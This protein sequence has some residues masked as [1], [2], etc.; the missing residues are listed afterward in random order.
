MAGLVRRV[1]RA[2]LVVTVSVAGLLF[3]LGATDAAA[4]SC[5]SAGDS[6]LVIVMTNEVVTLSKGSLSAINVNG[7][8]CAGKTASNTET[9][10][11]VASG[12]V[13]GTP[14][15]TDDG[16]LVVDMAGGR[17]EPGV[18]GPSEGVSINE[19]EIVVL[20]GDG[21]GAYLTRLEVR[22]NA[23]PDLVYAGDG[24]G[25]SD[26]DNG[27]AD[28]ALALTLGDADIDEVGIV[29]LNG[30]GDAD[31]YL[32]EATTLG[33]A[34]DDYS[35]VLRGRTGNDTLGGSG[36]SGTGPDTSEELL[37]DGG[38]GDDLLLGG[39]GDDIFVGG[40]GNDTIDGNDNASEPCDIDADVFISIATGEV[41]HTFVGPDGV[42]GDTVDYSAATGPI[43]ADLD[44]AEKHP[45]VAT[46]EGTDTLQNVENIA[47]SPANDTLSGDGAENLLI[48]NGGDDT[49]AGDSG[50]DC[51]FGADG[52]DT[53]DENEG[54]TVAQ[55]G[56]GTD[57]GADLLF[58]NR[59]LDDT[60]TYASRTT[61]VNVYLE[62]LD[63]IGVQPGE[64]S[65]CRIGGVRAPLSVPPRPAIEDGADLDGDGESAD[66]EGDCVFLDTENAITGSGNDVIA[67][68]FLNNRADNELTPNG[69]ND[70]VDGGAGNDTMH[71][72][73]A[74]NG[75][76]D[77]DGGTGADTCD[78]SGRANAVTVSLEGADN[79][80]ERGEGD[81]CGG[82]VNNGLE[83]QE[84]GDPI[85]GPDVE[86][87][88]GGSGGDTLVGDDDANVLTANGGNDTLSGGPGA[89]VL[90]GG[91]GDDTLAGERGNDALTG[92]AGSDTADYASA[93]AGGVGVH[94]NLARGT[95]SG[96]GNDSLADIENV[97]G[98]SFSDSLRGSSG[99]NVLSGHGGDDAI[100]GDA[101]D[102]RLNG[103]AGDDQL[104]G[105]S[106]NDEADGGGGADVVR[107]EGGDDGLSGGPGADTLAGGAGNDILSGGAGRDDHR[108]G[109]GSDRCD[110]GSPGLTG[111]DR[112]SGCER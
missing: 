42:E 47:G 13:L 6:D 112:A 69:G 48:G 98:S 45:G 77:F 73:T 38:E 30:D 89:D 52:N 29:N 3:G 74:A 72:G 84:E 76:D 75:S 1:A 2:R 105:G 64:E 49:L 53:L 51:V 14:V 19:V 36:G 15:V 109:A 97:S 16:T 24:Q 68:S 101:G 81:N 99:A 20:D 12:P 87:V 70:F 110:P 5:A 103:G 27:E 63:T 106:G 21:D 86:N 25:A 66:D 8:Q 102:D 104:S 37:F 46:G 31:I 78:Y 22:G 33:D 61:R 59:G 40:P 58:G 88:L 11:V 50:D 39:D 17:L 43:T 83:G 10:Y 18:D 57:N 90:S 4:F 67:A 108:G 60:V 107:G 71:E 111:G 96:E 26:G 85:A 56:T 55:G 54:T 44:P 91:D 28:A 41:V 35:V 65:V 92:G 95:T 32:A 100:Q 62:S 80:G 79:D 23:A 7:T 9:I 93:G 82:V 34:F 94:V